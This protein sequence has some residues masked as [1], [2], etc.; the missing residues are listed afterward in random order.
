MF[1][2]D[3]VYSVMQER[4]RDMQAEARADHDAAA[5]RKARKYWESRVVNALTVRRSRKAQ[6]AHRPATA[7]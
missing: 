3:I 5:V 7:R 4:V 2:N 1:H 6:Q